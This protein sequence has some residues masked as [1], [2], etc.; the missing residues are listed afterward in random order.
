MPQISINTPDCAVQQESAHVVNQTKQAL[1]D[2][3]VPL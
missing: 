1:L 2:S 3:G